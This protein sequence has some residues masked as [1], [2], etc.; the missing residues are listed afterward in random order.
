M[1]I[2]KVCTV[3]SLA[4]VINNNN[5]VLLRKINKNKNDI[6]MLK[7]LTIFN[8]LTIFTLKNEIDKIGKK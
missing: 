8:I 3:K 1:K 5:M 6:K 4:D 2:I 7:F